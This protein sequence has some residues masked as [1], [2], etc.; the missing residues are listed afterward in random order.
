MGDPFASLA[1]NA[2]LAWWSV[3][4]EFASGHRIDLH[5]KAANDSAELV[6]MSS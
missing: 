1:W 2:D 5:L 4:A 6:S 3:E